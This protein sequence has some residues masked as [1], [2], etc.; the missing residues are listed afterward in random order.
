[1]RYDT[2]PDDLKAKNNWVCAIKGSKLPLQAYVYTAA[3]TSNPGTWSS[4]EAA[5][6]AV[7]SGNYDY[8]G[9]VF[10]GDG[11]IGIDIDKG[12]DEDG[13]LSELSI[14]CMRA[15]RSYTE[16]SRS[17]RG[18]HIYVRGK[19]PFSGANNRNGLE[20]YADKRYFIVTGE[21]IIYD[22]II[23]NQAAIDYILERYFP[24]TERER[25]TG[26]RERIYSPVYKAP[27]AGKI[28]VSVEYP[29][30]LPG[31]RNLSLTS[32]AGQLHSQG[33]E[34]RQIYRELLK[35]NAS[36][37]SPPLPVGEIESIVR[38]VVRYKR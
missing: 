27:T 32:L 37:C 12:Y 25:E 14:D 13:F 4:Y 15:C 9:Y 8:L 16:Q 10:D 28:S 11:L 5:K 18:I 31:M 17:G 22:D 34:P 21:R 35:A 36:A 6:R 24:Q 7:S 3:S 30:I 2:I 23:E 33:Y 20:I 19:L 26:M 38:S 29:K 1:M